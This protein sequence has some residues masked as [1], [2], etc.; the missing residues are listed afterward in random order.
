M[1]CLELTVPELDDRTKQ[2]LVSGLTDVFA[3]ATNFGREIFGIRF[4]EYHVGQTAI[5]GRVWE[6]DGRPYLHFLLYSPRIARATKQTLVREFTTVYTHCVDK[7]DWKPV[8][9]IGEHPY[10]NVGVDG[11]ILSDSYEEC[12]KSRFYY[13][14]SED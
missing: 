10:D 3:E 11:S 1:P 13:D 9:H 12:A 14:L 4:N 2:T 7:P 5:G 6:G 8:I